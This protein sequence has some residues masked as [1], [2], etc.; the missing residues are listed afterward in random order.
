MALECP[1]YL[2]KV[3]Y[4]EISFLC[5]IELSWSHP[6]LHLISVRMCSDRL[7]LVQKAIEAR[8][9]VTYK[10]SQ[11]VRWI[12][13]SASVLLGA[14]PFS[15]C[16]QWEEASSVPLHSLSSHVN[17][18]IC[19]TVSAGLFSFWSLA[20]CWEFRAKM[21][22]RSKAKCSN[23]WLWQL[24]RTRTTQLLMRTVLCLWNWATPQFGLSAKRWERLRN[25][26][27]FRPSEYFEKVDMLH[28]LGKLVCA[29]V[30]ECHPFY[31]GEL[32]NLYVA[33]LLNL[34]CFF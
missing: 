7:S 32:Q 11:R 19:W 29:S 12:A 1:C 31:S 27:T 3:K 33:W 10:N 17:M 25:S 21:T 15:Y 26:M 4:F 13:M 9:K 2:C 18:G 28:C 24:S 23:L 30:L 16:I 14:L 6:L 5:L 8:P 20:F 34:Q 22:R